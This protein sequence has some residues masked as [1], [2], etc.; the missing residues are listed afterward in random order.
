MPTGFSLLGRD[1]PFREHC[2]RRVAAA[3]LDWV[4]FF[5]IGWFAAFFFFEA[6]PLSQR[7]IIAGFLSGFLL[8]IYSAMMEGFAGWTLGKR[9]A[10]LELG[11]MSVRDNQVAG[12]L[13]RSAPK[14]MW[15]VFLPIDWLLG[16]GIEGDPRQRGTDRLGSTV[17]VHT[18]TAGPYS[19]PRLYAAPP[20]KFPSAPEIAPASAA[21]EKADAP[22]HPMEMCRECKG[23]VKVVEDGRYRCTKC[24]LIQ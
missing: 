8:F 14:I 22:A 10:E 18:D 19:Q 1:K 24:G 7:L 3:L 5:V 6:Y 16:L 4:I 13:I 12:A 9:L 23:R 11:T 20:P 2:A 15:Y 17:V 21:Q